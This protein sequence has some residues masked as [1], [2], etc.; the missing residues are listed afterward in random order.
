MRRI[1]FICPT[2]NAREL[3]PYTRTALTSFLDT[4]PQGVAIVVDDGSRGWTD[5]YARSLQSLTQSRPGTEMHII[6]FPLAGGLTRS[7][8]AGLALADKLGLTYAIAGNNDVIFTPSWYS[9]MVHALAHGYDLV[10]PLSNAP[11]TTANGLQEIERYYSDYELTDDPVSLQQVA[12]TLHETYLGHVVEHSINGFFQMATL[13]SWRKGMYSAT[14]YYRP[15]NDIRSN[16]K[17]NPTPLTSGNEDELQQR[18]HQLEM[19]SAIVLS[20]F[21]FHYRAVSRGDAYKRGRWY[22]QA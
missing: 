13:D 10:G 18:W 12:Q 2:Y 5:A 9:G 11:G 7:W 8:N 6:Q 4:T 3:D 17:R 16:G 1:G 20:S 19:P 14:E 22:R 21:I 15:R